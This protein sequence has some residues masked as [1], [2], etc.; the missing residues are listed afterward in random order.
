MTFQ[1]MYVKSLVLFALLCGVMSSAFAHRDDGEYQILQARYGTAERNVDVTETLKE[2]ASRDRTFRMGNDSFGIDPHP[3]RIKILR[4]YARSDRGETRTFEYREGSLIDGSLFKGWGGGNW[5][6]SGDYHGA[7]E[8]R[9]SKGANAASKDN[10][11]DGEYV[12]LSARYGT[13]QRN[14]DVTDRL[15]ELA[16]SDSN[17]RMGNR[18]FGIDPH[19]NRVKTLRIY[20]RGNRGDVRTFEYTEGSVIDGALFK[21]WGRGDWGNRGD[22][23]GGWGNGNGNNNERSQGN[24]RGDEARN[25][26]GQFAQLTIV[27][28]YYGTES[29][30]I[31][32]SRAVRAYVRDGRLELK[33]EN[34]SLGSGDPVPGVAKTLWVTYSMGGGRSQTVRVEERAWLSLPR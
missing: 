13:E 12:I 2:L 26:S 15:K 7:W 10:R 18:S 5:G 20:A 16:R 9:G 30:K 11:D 27:S 6:R 28:A 32:V 14:V 8:D 17:F 33:V 1:K 31:D 21:S 4:I 22:Y 34:D 3:N 19:P 23:K 24:R 25:E 29:R